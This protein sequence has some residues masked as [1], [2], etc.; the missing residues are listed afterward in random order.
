MRTATRV[1][2]GSEVF[3]SQLEGYGV[4]VVFGLCG[5]T[6]IAVLDSLSRSKIEFVT[7]RHEQAAAHMADGYARVTGKPGVVLVHVGPG[8]MNAVTGVATAALDSVPLVVI[9]GD[10]PSYYYG[11][12]PHQEVNLHADS[13][14]SEIYRPFAKRVWRV[15]RIEDLPRFTERAFWT[16]QHGRPGA[17][18]LDV[19]MDMWSRPQ[20]LA[21]AERYPLPREFFGPALPPH[22]A[23][24]IVGKL[25]KAKR[26]MLFVGGGV[27]HPDVRDDVL[28]LAERLGIPIAHSLMAKGALPDSHPLLMGMTGFWGTEFANDYA[29]EADVVLALGTRFAETDSSSWDARFTWNA[30]GADLIHIDI[31]SNE[32]GRNFPVAVGAVA[33]L[34]HAARQLAAAAAGMPRGE[35][36]TLGAQIARARGTIWRE[37]EERGALDDFPLKPERI[38]EDVRRNLPSNTIFCTDVGWN[39]NGMAQRYRLPD[40]G[41]FITPG[42]LATMGFGPAA[43]IGAKYGARDRPVVALIGDGAMSSQLSALLTAVEQGIDV[44]WVVMNNSAFGTIADLENSHYGVQYGTVFKDPKGNPYTPDF[45][46]IARSCGAWGARVSSAGELAGAL[47]E[48]LAAKG[49]ALVDVPMVNDPVPTPGYWNIND[50]YKGVF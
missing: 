32:I 44:I 7:A 8:M 27:R 39:K 1:T 50:I 5:H 18:L 46:G 6:N 28:R 14:Q 29:R 4:E 11:R 22:T 34:R 42:G 37:T 9:A 2:T 49:P 20:N 36:T 19:P 15:D 17:V 48:A 41:V 16:A 25:A 45:A 38:L 43:A 40:D 31:D 13:S 24:E 35:W 12:H 33:D 21:L 23:D 30:A 10:I 26:P 3:V 47:R